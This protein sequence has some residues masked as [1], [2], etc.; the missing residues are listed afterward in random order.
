[1]SFLSFF[2]CDDFMP[3]GHC[4]LSRPDVI[5][6][7]IVSDGAIALASFSIPVALIF[8]IAK[9]P[10]TMF[11]RVAA[12]FGVFILACGKPSRPFPSR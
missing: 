2:S 1:M 6:Q 3:H 5:A 9:R 7:H 4:F 8:F 11:R 10:D 12:L